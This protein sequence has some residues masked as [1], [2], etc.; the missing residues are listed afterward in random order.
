MTS[1]RG[2]IQPGIL[3]GLEGGQHCLGSYIKPISLG[4]CISSIDFLDFRDN[5]WLFKFSSAG[6]GYCCLLSCQVGVCSQTA[7]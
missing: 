5:M 7:V 2:A 1:R 6:L 3:A 4:P